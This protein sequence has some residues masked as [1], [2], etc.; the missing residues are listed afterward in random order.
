MLCSQTTASIC[1]HFG[2]EAI[3]L[4][5]HKAM[6]K[7][8]YI[9]RHGETEFNKKGMVQGS[10]IDASLND[11][12]RLQAK[13]FYERY[14][15]IPFE[16]IFIS[17]LI[18]TKESVQSFIDDGVLCEMVEGLEEI[19]WGTQEGVAFTP[20][21]STIYQQTTERWTAGEID[22]KIEGGESP[23][24]VMT[25]QKRAMEYILKQNESLVLMC[26]HGRA[27]RILLSWMLGFPLTHMDNFKHTNTGLYVINVDNDKISLEVVNRMDH[28]EELDNQ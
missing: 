15:E 25:R 24:E 12:G 5:F 10:G 6:Q 1:G 19:S 7:K 26:I 11:T 20:E 14:R 22:A 2:Q 16:K 17:R 28:L 23:I 4:S 8:I 9:I 21:T 13:L 18:R 27:M 3:S